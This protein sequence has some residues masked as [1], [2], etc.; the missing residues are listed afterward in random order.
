MLQSI[1]D[2]AQ[3]IIVW[4]I[5]GLIIITFALFGLSSYL[6]GSAKS[7]VATVNGVE[8]SETD[9]LREYQNA[10]QRLQQM[11]G[12]NYRADLF[13]EQVMKQ[14]VL[15]GLI[16]R[17]VINQY[18]EDENYHVAPQQVV[19][20]LH[21]MPAFQDANG[22]F[23]PE[24]YHKVLSIQ[25]IPAEL[26]EMQ[27]ARDIENENLRNGVVR[28][29][30]VTEGEGKRYHGLQDQQRK[31]GYLRI[32]QQQYVDQIQ[33]SDDEIAAY[34]QQHQQEF[35]TPEEVAVDYVELNL[36]NIANQIDVSDAEVR[37]YYDQHQENYVSQQA[38]RKVRHILVK[39]DADTDEQTARK[40]I[41][42]I[43]TRIKNG[44]DF[45]T[46]AKAESQD[47]G[48]ASQGGD[49]G[50]I[51]PGVM[52]KAFEQAAFQ[53]KLHELS[54]PVRTRFGYH[55]IEVTQ[56]RPQELKPFDEVKAQIRKDLQVQ[57]AEQ[58]FYEEVDTLNNQSYEIPDSLAPVAEQLGLEVKKSPYFTKAGG[59][60]LF[61]NER[62]VNAAF[63]EDVL[64]LN[65]NSDLIELSD[66]HVVVL[67]LRDHKAAAQRP[68]DE[69]RQMIV[70]R[71]KQ[72]QAMEMAAKDAKA[73]L[74]RL[75]GSE[76]PQ[77]VAKE[78]QQKWQEPGFIKRQSTE[79]DKINEQIR[80]AAFALPHPKHDQPELTSLM[81]SGG[82]SVVLA[83]YAVQEDE[84]VK[85]TKALQAV[86]Q[87]L[88]NMSGQIEYSAFLA[89][90]TSQADITRN[91]NPTKE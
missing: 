9:L 66:T 80:E 90:L 54:Q 63:S 91:L 70:G 13:N 64:N 3:G 37:E 61:S 62:V 73:A 60:G 25:G 5:V 67:H 53:L 41:E 75:A 42:S 85:D 56:I 78:Y 79:T 28:T 26:F 65:R 52:D 38:Q 14:Q 84:P 16:Q 30:F 74:E 81:L 59:E 12:E 88:A 34:Y 22:Q 55:L 77:K 82:D 7:V 21:R 51:S 48:S 4:T 33:V 1:R 23:S 24:N 57:Q 43:A 76:T 10:Q 87:Q 83:L 19:A 2:R 45:A 6:S 11:L 29:T 27:L 31:I 72:Q 50:F 17:E 8:I 46:I 58:R 69:V 89:Y 18:L 20:T 36:A 71:I 49:L 86:K 47:P 15:E 40:K 68:L 32:P 35:S 44:E 39:V